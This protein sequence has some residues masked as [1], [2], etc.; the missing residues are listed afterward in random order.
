MRQL[1][2]ALAVLLASCFEQLGD[3]GG[4]RPAVVRFLIGLFQVPSQNTMR[5]FMGFTPD[6]FNQEKSFRG[7]LPFLVSLWLKKAASGKDVVGKA[8]A[9]P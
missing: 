5:F 4:A 3:I 1:L 8:L 7:Q 2:N 9:L 6:C